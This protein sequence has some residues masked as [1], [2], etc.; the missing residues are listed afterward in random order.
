MGY[1]LRR[2]DVSMDKNAAAVQLRN[3]PRLRHATPIFSVA[4]A[5][6]ELRAWYGRDRA[7]GV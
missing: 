4:R 3:P 5:G 6:Y 2:T 7:E 1:A